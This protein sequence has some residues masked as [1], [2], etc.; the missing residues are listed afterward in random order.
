MKYTLEVTI[1][2]VCNNKVYGTYEAD[3]LIGLL[4]EV[5]KHRLHHLY[6]GDG[7]ID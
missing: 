4:Y 7:F 3:T 2:V 6:N 5:L 1:G